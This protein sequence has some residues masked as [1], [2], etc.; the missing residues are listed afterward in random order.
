M[1][2]LPGLDLLRAI[3]IVWVMFFHAAGA[4]LGSPYG[5]M[6]E[7]GWM[8]VDLF[9]A[10]SGYLIGWQVLKPLSRGE[11]LRWG[12]F[13]L[14]R[15]MRVL[16]AFWVV[17][18]LYLL[19]PEFRERPG[20]QPA[21]Q[22]LT[23]TVNLLIDYQ[24]N[25]AFSHAWSLC[26]EE[27][28]Y[29]VFPLLAWGLT[30]RPALWKTLALGV[31]LVAG[32]MV[33][34]AWVWQLSLPDGSTAWV[35]RVYYPTWMRL[36]GLLAGVMLAAIRAYRPSWWAA[37]MQRS[38]LLLALGLA[39]VAAAIWLSQNRL[40]LQASVFGF[41]VVSFGLALLVAAAASEHRWTGRLRVPGAAWLAAASF[42]LYLTHKQMFGLVSRHY[43][44]RLDGQGLLAFAA[45]AAAALLGGALLYYAVER[46]FLRLR[47]RI[48]QRREAQGEVGSGAVL[49][50]AQ[51]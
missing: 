14:R 20:M 8:G 6:S 25:K 29:L 34:R 51:S 36:D 50:A 33:L 48:V 47:D 22:F 38:G 23:F 32:G 46:P 3:A 42:S 10:L 37:M 7:F 19:V 39:A 16:P 4:G 35:E 41:P 40:G 26:V 15:A 31:L 24:H 43:G 21:W 17:I 5:P 18:A 30:R 44:D 45:Y 27:H 11:P 49:P 2:R 28:F 1:S 12:D 13:Y 9:F